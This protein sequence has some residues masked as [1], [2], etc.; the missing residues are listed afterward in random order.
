MCLPFLIDDIDSDRFT[1]FG[2]DSNNYIFGQSMAI[3][4]SG[5][6]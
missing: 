4:N 2:I 5:V 1:S 3:D 6:S